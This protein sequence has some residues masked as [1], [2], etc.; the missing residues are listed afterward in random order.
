M[1]QPCSYCGQSDYL[2]EHFS[3][4]DV[5]CLCCLWV[6]YEYAPKDGNKLRELSLTRRAELDKGEGI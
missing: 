2:R 1:R 5:V 4:S 3:F 6:W